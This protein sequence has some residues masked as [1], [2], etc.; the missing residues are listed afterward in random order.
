MLFFY[1]Q[2]PRGFEPIL[3]RSEVDCFTVKLRMFNAIYSFILFC[4]VNLILV[5]INIGAYHA[6][7]EAKSISRSAPYE[8]M[9]WFFPAPLRCVAVAVAVAERSMEEMQSR[10]AP[11]RPKSQT[12]PYQHQILT[13]NKLLL[14]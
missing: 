4:Y 10:H 12:R 3:C 9:L 14:Y 11:Y 8:T 13:K 6:K 2:H 5:N 1:F 7:C